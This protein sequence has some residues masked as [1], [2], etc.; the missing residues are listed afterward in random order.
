MYVIRGLSAEQIAIHSDQLVALLC[1]AVDCGASVG[2]LPPLQDADAREYWGSVRASIHAGTRVLLGALENGT[3]VGAVQL[4]LATSPNGLHRAEVM[5][6]FV[7]RQHRRR[8]IARALM[9]A[10]EEAARAAGRALLVL[11]TRRGDTAE[12]LYLNLGYTAAG[13]I[14]RYA[15]SA[16]GSLDD[17]VYM[18]KELDP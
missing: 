4:D 11:D 17:T 16:S 6:L 9:M 2:F 13:V 10:V 12:Q 8:G 18:Y 5:K 14:P 1:D 15:R 3:V 7:H